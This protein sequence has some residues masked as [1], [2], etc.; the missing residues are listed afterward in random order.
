MQHKLLILLILSIMAHAEEPLVI[1]QS[2][3]DQVEQGNAE[4]A[5]YIAS[6]FNQRNFEN[7]DTDDENETKKWMKK[8]AEMDYPQA[9]FEWGLMLDYDDEKKQALA[10]YQKAAESG[11]SDAMEKI[12]NFYIFGFGGLSTDC[13]EAY[14]WYKKAELVENKLAY[15]DHAWHLATASDKSCRSPERALRLIT[16]LVGLY[17]RE[18]NHVPPHVLD[19]QAAVFASVS[20]FNKAIKSQEKAIELLGE[21]NEDLGS[22]QERLD[23]YTQRKAWFQK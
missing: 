6:Q 16:K 19:T 20:E 10:W 2:L 15:N 1:P 23:V 3:I 7:P 5:Y 18:M 4:V 21:N 8:A 12:G 22:Y 14:E 9:M 17:Q 13:Q 11:L